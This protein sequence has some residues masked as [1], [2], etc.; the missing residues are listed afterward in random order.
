MVNQEELAICRRRGHVLGVVPRP[1]E[2][3]EQCEKCGTWIRDVLTREER[4]DEP[5]EAEWTSGRRLDKRIAELKEQ[6]ERIEVRKRDAAPPAPPTPA[7]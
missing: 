2:G 3:Y 4:E 5:P 6:V 7:P 1:G